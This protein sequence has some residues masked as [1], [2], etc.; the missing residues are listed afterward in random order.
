MRRSSGSRRL[1]ELRVRC[2]SPAECRGPVTARSEH[3]GDGVGPGGNV[4]AHA[5][6]GVAGRKCQKHGPQKCE[7]PHVS[8]RYAARWSFF[9]PPQGRKIRIS[10]VAVKLHLFRLLQGIVM[11]DQVAVGK[12]ER[13]DVAP[14]S[15]QAVKRLGGGRGVFCRAGGQHRG[16]GGIDGRRLDAHPVAR[17]FGIG[18]RGRPI[19]ILFVDRRD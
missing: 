6:D 16:D 10:P 9:V 4:F 3:P 12:P 15:Q 19:E 2:R 14:G 5:A 1:S 17:P 8:T 11:D 18:C 13:D 7:F